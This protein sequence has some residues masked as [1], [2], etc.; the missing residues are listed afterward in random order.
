[1]HFSFL[2]FFT[3]YRCFIPEGYILYFGLILPAGM[4]ILFIIVCSIYLIYTVTR[5]GV[6]AILGSQTNIHHVSRRLQNAVAAALC[7]AITWVSAYVVSLYPT[8]GF[9]VTFCIISVVQGVV[10]FYV[11]C[12]CHDGILRIFNW[13]TTRTKCCHRATTYQVNS[14]N[15]NDAESLDKALVV[16]VSYT[17][18]NEHHHFHNVVF[19]I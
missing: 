15:R 4:T 7:I 9:Q 3:W 11:V 2:F 18:N 13:C 8:Y 14:T 5:P 17:A 16:T 1:M 12:L 6:E 19:N 10:L